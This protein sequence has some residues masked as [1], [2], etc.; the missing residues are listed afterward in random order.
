MKKDNEKEL[1]E[2]KLWQDGIKKELLADGIEIDSDVLAQQ[3]DE[4]TVDEEINAVVRQIQQGDEDMEK[5]K[6]ELRVL[7]DQMSQKE[8]IASA[9]DEL[10]STIKAKKQKMADLEKLLRARP[11]PPQTPRQ[12]N[13]A[14]SKSPA[15]PVIHENPME[16]EPNEVRGTE[17]V[18]DVMNVT[19]INIDGPGPSAQS[20]PMV[21]SSLSNPSL[22]G[23]INTTQVNKMMLSSSMHQQAES[24]IPQRKLV[25]ESASSNQMEMDTGRGQGDFASPRRYA[26]DDL[27]NNHH[28]GRHQP[29]Y[30]SQVVQH[31]YSPSQRQGPKIVTVQSPTFSSRSAEASPR[32]AGQ[33][34]VGILRS[35]LT[36]ESEKDYMMMKKSSQEY[37]MMKKSSQPRVEKESDSGASF[38]S[39]GFSGKF[40]FSSRDDN[41]DDDNNGFG[42]FSGSGGGFSGS[43]SGFGFS[44]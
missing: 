22:K 3:T 4:E 30:E 29:R 14:V 20:T 31:Q 21:M 16:E 9:V 15:Q 26:P 13:A 44:F 1:S 37:M 33:G 34:S 24:P 23:L 42:G 12:A 36:E 11:N 32:S 10:T 6:A 28:Y 8:S 38:G 41:Q 18:D 40:G 35:P 27:P 39:F 7:E 17:P 43:S 19:A 5:M 2:L 25:S